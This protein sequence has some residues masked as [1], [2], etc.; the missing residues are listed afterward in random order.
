M[1][2]TRLV[3]LPLTE[4]LLPVGARLVGDVPDDEELSVTV[5]VRRR[6]GAPDL[7]DPEEVGSLPLLTQRSLNDDAFRRS[8]SADATD[9]DRVA[10]FAVEHGLIIESREPLA[11]SVSLRGTAGQMQEAFGVTLRRYRSDGETF[12]GRSGPVHVPSDLA[13][14]VEAVFGLDDRTVGRPHLRRNQRGWGRQGLATVRARGLPPGTFLPPAVAQLYR[15]PPGT[16]GNGQCVGILNF[17]DPTSHGGYSKEALRTYFEQVLGL[18]L[19][20]ITDIVVHGQGNDPGTDDGS[21]PFDTSG[22]VM[23]DVQTVGACAPRAKIVMYFTRFTE[24]GWVDAINAVI[25]DTTNRPSVVSISYGN[26]EDDSR[27]AWTAA[28]IAKVNQAFQAAAA[29]GVT[30]CC[31]SGDDGSRDQAGDGLAHVD[32][33]AS[34]P[35]VLGCGGT[36]VAARFGSI[37]HETVWNDGAGGATGGGVSRLFPLPRYQSRAFVPASANPDHRT[38]RGVPDVSG[39]ADP[40]TGVIIG[41]LDGEHVAVVGG[42]SVTSPLWSALM[43]RLNQALGTSIGFANPLLYRFL[44]YPVLRDITHGSN[45]AYRAGPGWDACTGL[46]SPDGINLLAAV[47]LLVAQANPV[48]H[49]FPARGPD[50]APPTSWGIAMALHGPAPAG[51]SRAEGSLSWNAPGETGPAP[52]LPFLEAVTQLR[53]ALERAWAESSAGGQD[54]GA[55][56]TYFRHAASAAYLDYV[57]TVHRRWNEVRPSELDPASLGGISLSVAAGA[58]MAGAAAAVGR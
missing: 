58:A 39:L 8:Q 6:P 18:P 44:G 22:E 38:G 52:V 23:L 3:P 27:S 24:Q 33:P 55:R 43:A 21:D 14:V 41:T 5:Y 29:R 28:A 20:D 13:G 19:P 56:V 53:T 36:R 37:L 11:R 26:P 32:F 2:S 7:P 57:G 17:N 16:D 9:L 31:A 10:A 51:G 47:Q 4:R 48:P 15:F 35:Y 49:T 40:E 12:R 50:P 46:G 1:A 30:I 25:T 42:T 54:P 34:S 45:G